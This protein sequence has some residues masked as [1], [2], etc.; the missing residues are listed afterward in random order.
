MRVIAHRPCAA[1]RRPSAAAAVQA[2]A[3]AAAIATTAAIATS[4]ATA[5]SP[6]GACGRTELG[7][8]A[9]R[10]RVLPELRLGRVVPYLGKHQRA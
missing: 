9:R 6:R 3:E 7:L 4:A 5:V 10:A 2:V 8:R 1:I